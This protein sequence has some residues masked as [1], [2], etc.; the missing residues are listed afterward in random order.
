MFDSATREREREREREGVNDRRQGQS[1]FLP[2]EI[3]LAIQRVCASL[4]GRDKGSERER[5]RERLL[6]TTVRTIDGAISILCSFEFLGTNKFQFLCQR[7]PIFRLHHYNT[8]TDLT[9]RNA[10]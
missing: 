9:K 4:L 7:R 5:E 8:G 10:A 2:K 6:P 3:L 1:I